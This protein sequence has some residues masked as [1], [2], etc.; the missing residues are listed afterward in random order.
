MQTI[1]GS[2]WPRRATAALSVLALS[3]A[4][5]VVS[6]SPA[7][8]GPSKTKP[9]RAATA[10][11]AIKDFSYRPRTLRIRRGTRVVFVNRDRAPHTATKRGSFDTGRLRKGGKATVRFKRRGSYAYICTIHPFM[12]GKIVVR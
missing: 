4:L 11:V 10:R 5:F 9:R 8:A 1:S 3:A 6:L 2:R 7:S 12:R